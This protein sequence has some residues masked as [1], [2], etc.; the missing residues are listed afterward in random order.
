MG[1]HYWNCPGCGASLSESGDHARPSFTLC[2]VC[3]ERAQALQVRPEGTGRE[4]SE[5][6]LRPEYDE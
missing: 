2:A 6:A 3:A 5:E 1:R 4:V